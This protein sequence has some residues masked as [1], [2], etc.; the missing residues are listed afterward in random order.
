MPFFTPLT[1]PHTLLLLTE[2]A[3]DVDVKVHAVVAVVH[4]VSVLQFDQRTQVVFFTV[5]VEGVAGNLSRT[6]LKF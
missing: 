2:T 6:G 5:R 4:Q 3:A 1:L